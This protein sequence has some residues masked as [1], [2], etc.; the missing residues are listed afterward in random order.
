VLLYQDCPRNLLTC[1]FLSALHQ[2]LSQVDFCKVPPID[3]VDGRLGLEHLE[4]KRKVEATKSELVVHRVKSALEVGSRGIDLASMHLSELPPVL[5]ALEA[6]KEMILAGNLL[7]NGVIE[8][9]GKFGGLQVLDLS[10]NL[11]VGE[12]PG[13]IGDLKKMKEFR[14]DGECSLASVVRLESPCP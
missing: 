13:S 6:A 14:C 5:D 2:V 11:L 7:V 4:L 10:R 9:L 12:L 1:Q 3:G 8:D